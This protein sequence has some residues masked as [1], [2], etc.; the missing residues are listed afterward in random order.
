MVAE[1]PDRYYSNTTRPVVIDKCRA[2]T[3]PENVK[4]LRQYVTPQPKIVVLTRDPSEI[5][6]SFKS[7][8]ARNNR[9]DFDTSG[10]AD[11]FNRNMASTQLAKDAH[12]LNTFLFV[13][14]NDLL[15]DTQNQLNRIYQF[16]GM[17][18]YQHD[19]NNIVTVNPENDEVYGLQGMHN[20]RPTISY[21]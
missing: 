10:M 1:L 14:F 4:M 13:E 2:W 18:Q 6:A 8:F 12:D 15:A 17:E 3:H 7:L 19:L 9:N 11:E 16:L 5:I 20:V 21:I